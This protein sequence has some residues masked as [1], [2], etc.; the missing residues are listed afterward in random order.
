MGIQY[1]ELNPRRSKIILND[2]EYYLRPFDLAAQVWCYEEFK[3][4]TEPNGIVALT[5]RLE[6]V[7]DIAAY[8]KVVFHLLEDKKDFGIYAN[9]I[10]EIEKNGKYSK[11]IELYNA[12]V[13]SLGVS[14]PQID[15]IKKE[16][17]LK[18][19]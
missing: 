5:K 16:L 15:K 11:T 18:K 17:E 3:T 7:Q 10:N 1:H 12:L 9:F 8:T 2:K 13:E 19:P 14:Q 4:E 6:D